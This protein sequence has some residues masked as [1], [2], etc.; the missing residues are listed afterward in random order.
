MLKQGLDIRIGQSLSMTPQLQQAIRL[1]QL[2]SIELETEIQQALEENPLLTTENEYELEAPNEPAATAEQAD[3]ESSQETNHADNTNSIVES[4]PDDLAVDAEWSDVFDVR[5]HNN[6]SDTDLQSFLENQSG[7]GADLE[8]HLL[9][10]VSMSNLS[11]IDK[12]IAEVIISCIDATGYL[13]EDL[14]DICAR[15]ENELLIELDDVEVV[16][17]FIQQLDPIGVGARDLRECMLLQLSHLPEDDLTQ[18]TTILVEKYLDLF[19]QRLYKDI[20]KRLKI[21]QATLENMVGL[22]KTLDPKPGQQYSAAATD[23]IVPDVYVQKVR[24]QWLVTLN[25]NITPALQVNNLYAEMIGKDKDAPTN[26]YLKNNL[27]QAKWLI[28]SLDNRNHT[29]L[30]VAQTIVERQSAFMQYGE[31]AMKPMVLRDIAEILDM[32]ESTIS[33]VTTNKY[34]HTPRGVYEFKYFFSSQLDTATGASCSSTAIRAM[35]KQLISE[36]NQ[37]SPL[38]DS[39]LTKLL[40]EQGINVARRTVAKYREAMSIP[41][42]HERKVLV[43]S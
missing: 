36:E 43:A 30:N 5:S 40:K 15:L 1:L 2:S 32:H 27:Q 7:A 18:K 12:Q 41:S 37:K 11:A 10:Q 3:R 29:I 4:I 28:R 38:S 8:A 25:K 35:I 33:R 9:W 39:R 26:D 21:T 24:G 16:L 42:S 20:K 19:E 23:Y 14:E 22:L 31:Q 6:N 17:K 34:M 13:T